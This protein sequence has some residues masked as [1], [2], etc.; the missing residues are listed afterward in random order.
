MERRIFTLGMPSV[1]GVSWSPAAI[2]QNV[3]RQVQI[4]VSFPPG[5]IADTLARV[6]GEALSR[7]WGQAVVVESRPGA[8]G[9]IGAEY[10][11]RAEPNARTLLLD[12]SAPLTINP[13]LIETGFDPRRELASI[14]TVG[15]VVVVNASVPARTI[16]E[17]ATYAKSKPEGLSYGSPSIASTHH[18]IGE[19]LQ[20]QLG[21]K[22]VHVPYKGSAAEG[23]RRWLE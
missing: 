5:G 21:V 12:S 2:S 3:S 19:L 6:M 11:S 1:A 10:V 7:L 20:R 14:T 23:K 22:L 9:Y 13:H 17:L 8:S 16:E 15:I 4:V 18:L